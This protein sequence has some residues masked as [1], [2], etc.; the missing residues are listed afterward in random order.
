MLKQLR[1]TLLAN[2][3][4]QSRTMVRACLVLLLI[5]VFASHVTQRCQHEWHFPDWKFFFFCAMHDVSI[6]ASHETHNT[7]LNHRSRHSLTIVRL[8]SQWL[9]RRVCLNYFIYCRIESTNSNGIIIEYY[10][11]YDQR[12]NAGTSMYTQI[13]VYLS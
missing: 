9:A 4:L 13:I 8:W 12:K 10:Y 6:F 3:W 7:L 2:H 5:S 1:Q 11:F